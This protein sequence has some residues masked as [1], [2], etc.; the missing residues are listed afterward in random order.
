MSRKLNGKL[1]DTV[2]RFMMGLPDNMTDIQLASTI[3]VLLDS[4]VDTHEQ[5]ERIL[6]SALQAME[7]ADDEF[8]QNEKIEKLAGI[9][10][11]INDANRFLTKVADKSDK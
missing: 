5:R 4:F 1:A 2:H 7:D 8:L 10:G 6:N 9:A 11:A 3:C